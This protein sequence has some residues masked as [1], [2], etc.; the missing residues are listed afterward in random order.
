MLSRAFRAVVIAAVALMA[1]V[2]PAV[3]DTLHLKDGRVLEGRVSSEGDGYVYFVIKV[4]SIEHTELFA[5]D[6]IDKIERSE[7]VAGNPTNARATGQKQ[8]RAV[9]PGATKVAFISLRDE[10]GLFM[11]AGALRRSVELAAKAEPDII[12]LVVNS[13]GGA[14]LEVEKLSDVIH[15]E[16]KKNY[17]VVAWIESAISAA[18]MTSFNCE[19][20][21]MTDQ[22]N[23]GAA[24]AFVQ[25][26]PG[27]TQAAQG[28]DLEQILAL[29]AELSRRGKRN[30]LILRAMQVF[31]DLSCDIDD[32]G[33]ITWRDD[34]KGEYVVN[35]KERILTLNSIDSVKY[36]VARGIAN[37]K[38][39][40][41]K[42]MGVTEW[43]EVGQAGEEYQQQFRKNVATVQARTNEL[44]A[45]FDLALQAASG[46]DQDTRNRFIGRA[47]NYLRELQSLVRQAPSF[48]EYTI[49]KPEWFREREDELRRLSQQNT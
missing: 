7:D 14:L 20:M 27:Q 24:V 31:M 16:M 15:K 1:L 35:R 30:P 36:G 43:A 11:N 49:F 29:G 34:D 4:G 23:I 25:T 17:R 6:Q 28:A 3:A 13:P 2:A 40:L 37:S 33:I 21:Y 42:V 39:E 48:E 32:N 9:S 44:L 46:G 8:A 18:A 26:G 19:E 22:G 10:V 12:V 41:M 45:K 38:D 47:R 5:R